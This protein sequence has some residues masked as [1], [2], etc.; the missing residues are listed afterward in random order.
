MCNIDDDAIII[1]PVFYAAFTLK[2]KEIWRMI[3]IVTLNTEVLMKVWEIV[4]WIRFSVK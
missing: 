1:F 4:I 3:K 2:D